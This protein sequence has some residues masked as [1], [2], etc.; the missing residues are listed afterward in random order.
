ME[1]PRIRFSTVTTACVYLCVCGLCRSAHWLSAYRPRCPII[2]VSRDEMSARQLRLYRGVIPLI[3]TGPPPS[4]H[5]ST[6][7]PPPPTRALLT[8]VLKTLETTVILIIITHSLFH[9]RLK[10][11]FFCKSFPPQPFLFFFWTDYMIPPDCLPLL[12]NI[13]V[14]TFEFFYFTLFSCRFRAVD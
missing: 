7:S 12:L 14:F 10:T 8:P 13:S 11:F 2:A 3:Y 5:F 1:F 6:P 9:S 4:S